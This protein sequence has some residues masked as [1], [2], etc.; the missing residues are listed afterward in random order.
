[1]LDESGNPVAKAVVK[2]AD[3]TRTVDERN[4]WKISELPTAIYT[5]IISRLERRIKKRL[6]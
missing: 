6:Y 3:K 5:I 4:Y 1:M 2:F